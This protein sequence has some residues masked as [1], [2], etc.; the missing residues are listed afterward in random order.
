MSIYDIPVTTI[1]GQQ[2]TLEP[3]R[4]QVLLIVNVASECGFTPQYV[5]LEKLYQQYKDRGFSVLGFPCNQFMS[6][7][8]GSDSDIQQFCSSKF[9]VTFPMFAKIDVNGKNTHPLYEFLKNAKSGTF[10]LKF[11]K[12]NFA[13]F[14]IGRDG[15]V[16]RRFGTAKGPMSIAKHVEKAL[17]ETPVGV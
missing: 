1:D 11:I 3:Y 8:P 13:K 10:G 5:G 2:T 6:Q 7:E 12:W 14:L 15:T 9:H 4:G 17:L 16:L